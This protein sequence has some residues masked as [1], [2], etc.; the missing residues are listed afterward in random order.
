MISTSAEPTW[1]AERRLTSDF[2]V[3][4]TGCGV[5]MISWLTFLRGLNGVTVAT[6]AKD[7]EVERIAGI[8]AKAYTS[9]S[10]HICFEDF[11]NDWN[12]ALSL[13]K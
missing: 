4:S 7:G 6:K 1:I 2:N 3:T 9:A 5:I 11:L 8:L 13:R 12:F 10:A